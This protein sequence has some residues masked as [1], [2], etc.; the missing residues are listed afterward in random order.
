MREE[1]RAIASRI[2]WFSVSLRTNRFQMPRRIQMRKAM[3]L[4][5]IGSGILLL[6]TVRPGLA[7]TATLRPLPVK[8]VCG[9]QAPDFDFTAPAEPPVK[10]GNYATVINIENLTTGSDGS[11]VPVSIGWTV[12]V[13]GLTPAAGA[14]ITGLGGLATQDITCADIASALKSPNGF[15]SGYVN[16]TPVPPNVTT[17]PELAVTAV[18][19]AQ[20]CNFPILSTLVPS[21][22]TCTGPVSTKVVPFGAAASLGNASF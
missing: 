4:A 12:S 14:T 6:S 1:D 2:R 16:I 7:Q 8:F 15:I 22:P 3:P 17:T 10:P 21:V 13:P 5:L 11:S 9:R 19:T 18:Y 20:G